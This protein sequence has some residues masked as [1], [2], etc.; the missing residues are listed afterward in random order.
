M[1][2]VRQPRDGKE[3]EEVV[4][5]YGTIAPG[6]QIMRDAM[7]R[8]ML[9]SE[10]GGILSIETEAAGVMN[11]LPSLMIRGV[12]DY[13]DSHKNKRWQPYAAASAAAYAKV[14]LSTISGLEY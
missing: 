8:Y 12:C 5:H 3:E 1:R 14:V 13:A 11:I 10:L 4:V 2:K 7:A 9:S 6:G